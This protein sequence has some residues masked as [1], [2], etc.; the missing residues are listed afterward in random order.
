MLRFYTLGRADE[1]VIDE[2][3]SVEEQIFPFDGLR[4]SRCERSTSAESGSGFVITRSI[5]RP[6]A[7]SDLSE[8]AAV[9]RASQKTSQTV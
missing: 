7:L 2:I 6:S 8:A 4:C 1:A 9:S 3:L 5:L